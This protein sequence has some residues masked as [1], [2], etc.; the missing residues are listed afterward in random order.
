MVAA[1]EHRA[2][3]EDEWMQMLVLYSLPDSVYLL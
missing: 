2:M 1:V 3:V